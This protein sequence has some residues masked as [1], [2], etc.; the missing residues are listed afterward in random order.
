MTTAGK[1]WPGR[2]AEGRRGAQAG[3]GR[4]K[5]GSEAEVQRRTRRTMGG[6]VQRRGRSQGAQGHW[7]SASARRGWQRECPVQSVPKRLSRCPGWPAD[8]DWRYRSS[9]RCSEPECALP[10]RL[11][12]EMDLPRT[13]PAACRGE[14]NGWRGSR[15]QPLKRQ[16]LR[17][18][19][20]GDGHDVQTPRPRLNRR[21][22]LIPCA[23]AATEQQRAIAACGRPAIGRR[24]VDVRCRG[25]WPLHRILLSSFFSLPDA[26]MLGES[27]H[28]CPR[29]PSAPARSRPSTNDATRDGPSSRAVVWRQRTPV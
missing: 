23:R 27:Q 4:R 18:P 10:S 16:N 28:A 26:V 7:R 13:E 25:C 9:F 21:K 14:G 8:S 20:A 19:R 24:R 11:R 1:S 2:S 29:A 3:G 17:A 15:I 12:Q 5:D 22:R 6:R